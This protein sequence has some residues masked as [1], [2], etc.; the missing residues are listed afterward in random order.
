MK[1]SIETKLIVGTISIIMGLMM[2]NIMAC[3]V[4]G[5]SA[6]IGDRPMRCSGPGGDTITYKTHDAPCTG[7]AGSQDHFDTSLE[8]TEYTQEYTCIFVNG[9]WLPRPGAVSV[10]M[11]TGQQITQC[12]A[13]GAACTPSPS[14]GN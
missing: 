5:R 7:G 3:Y 8:Q 10:T 1:T 6:P 9:H 14:P 13:S 4:S 11:G 2:G 12:S